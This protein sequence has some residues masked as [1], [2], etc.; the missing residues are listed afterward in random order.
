MTIMDKKRKS[1][2]SVLRDKYGPAYFRELGLKGGKITRDRYGDSHYKELGQAGGKKT[3]E[4]RGRE[5]YVAMGKRSHS[6]NEHL[7]RKG[8]EVE[9]LERELAELDEKLR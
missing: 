6:A 9:E 8:L 1:G 5:H 4:E 3:L 7:I 2:G